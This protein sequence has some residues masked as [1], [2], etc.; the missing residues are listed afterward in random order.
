[1]GLPPEITAATGMDAL[2]HAIE[3]FI[4]HSTTKRTAKMATEAI[5]LIFQNLA[6][7]VRDG[8]NLEARSAMQKAAFLAG[9]AFTRSYLGYV[10]AITHNLG[11]FYHIP[12]GEANAVFLPPVLEYYGMKAW[13]RLSLL[14]I[15]IGVG[16]A[17]YTDQM[18]AGIFIAALKEL[19]HQIGMPDRFPGVLKAEDLPLIVERAYHEANPS[20]PV[21][22]FMERKEIERIIRSVM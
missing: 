18:N 2:T 9:M 3:A 7:A 14:A 8:A 5:V 4:G 16:K 12:H 15:A 22:R 20:A 6:T 13:K 1:M 19:S 17:E 21:P 10:H 11:G